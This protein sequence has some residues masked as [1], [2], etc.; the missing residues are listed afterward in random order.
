M[1]PRSAITPWDDDWPQLGCSDIRD[2]V[3]ALLALMPKSLIGRL[4]PDYDLS[5]IELFLQIIDL[6]PWGYVSIFRVAEQLELTEG[7][8]ENWPTE[9]KQ[10]IR[11]GRD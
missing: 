1:K 5:T 10:A 6:Y 3:Y 4:I 2:R 8:V 9:V 7:S 11:S